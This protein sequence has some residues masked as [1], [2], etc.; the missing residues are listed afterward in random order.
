MA[1]S[2]TTLTVT[3]NENGG[4]EVADA[5]GL[6]YNATITKPTTTRTGYTFNGWYDGNRKWDF[7]NGKVTSDL[8]LTAHWTLNAPG[9][10]LTADKTEA[11]YNG[12]GAVITLTAKPSHA[13]AGVSYTYAWYKDGAVISGATDPT[14]D[15]STVADSGSY[16]VKVT[17]SAWTLTS[18]QAESAAVPVTIGKA[19][20]SYDTPTGLTATYGDTLSQVDLP[21]A[22]S[23]TWAWADSTGDVGGA[24]TQSHEATFTP[25]DKD[26]Y[27]VVENIPVT[28]AVKKKALT[29]SVASVE[30]KVYD[31]SASTTGTIS[32]SGA[33]KGENPAAT[34]T[35]TFADA[36]AGTGKAVNVAVALDSDWGDNYTISAD[37]LE[38]S[39]NITPRPV[40]LTWDYAGP[41]TYTG[42][43]QAVTAAVANA[44]GED[45]FE[46]AY[47]DNEKTD[48]GTYTARVTGLGNG[49][50]T[51]DGGTGATQEWVI[52]PAEI[53]FTVSGNS[54]VYD[55]QPKIAEASQTPGEEPRIDPG[56]YTVTYDGAESQTN[57]GEY[58]ITVTL[59]DSNFTFAGNQNSAVVG[60]LT[61]G[62]AQV[63]I[64]AGDGTKFFYD[65]Q[66]KT[67]KIPDNDGYDVTGQTQTNAGHYTVTVSLKDNYV[68]TDG[69][70][71]EKEYDFVIDPKPITG[72]WDGLRQ[73]YGDNTPVTVTLLGLAEGDSAADV[74][75]A[76]ID[77]TGF[78][79]GDHTITAALTGDKAGNYTLTN[80]TK[81]LTVNQKPLIFT[82]SGNTVQ[83][84]NVTAP[85]VTPSA[86]NFN[87]F[88]IVYKQGGTALTGLPSAPGV[89]EV[90]VELTDNNYTLSGGQSVGKVGDF[91]ITTTPP[92]LYT[93]SFASGGSGHG[94]EPQRVAA[95]STLTLPENPLTYAGHRF[96][97][98]QAEGENRIY[99]PGSVYIMPGRDVTFNAQWT[100]TFSVNGNVTVPGDG[101]AATLASDVKVSIW[102]GAERLAEDTTGKNGSFSFSDLLPGVYNLVATRGEQT[103]TVMVEITDKD[104]DLAIRMPA[105]GTANSVVEVAPAAPPVVADGV[106][107]VAAMEKPEINTT[108]TITLSVEPEQDADEQ[109]AVNEAIPAASQEDALYLDI[110]LTKTKTTNGQTSSDGGDIGSTNQ[111][112]LELLVPYDF[113]GKDTVTVY[114]KHGTEDAMALTALSAKPGTA[115][116]D[117]TFYADK[118]NGRVYIYASKFSTY[119]IAYTVQGSTG[120]GGGSGGGGG[121]SSRPTYAPE[122]E[123]GAHGDVTVSPKR[124][125]RGD[126]VIITPKPDEGYEAVDVSVVDQDGKPVGVEQNE[127]GTWSFIQPSG[128]VTIEVIFREIGQTG[129]C[130]RDNTCP[131][132]KF[133]DVD[134]NAWYHDG[135]HYCLE[136]GLMAGTGASTFSPASTTTR[137][138]IVTIL[139]RQA[140]SPVVNY[141]MDFS[142][143]PADAYYTEA[144]RWAASEGVAGGYGNGK[145]GSNDPITREQLAAMLYHYAQKYGY[146]VS[147]GEDTN[148]LSYTDFGQI[149]EYAVPAMQWACG[150]GI[151][152]G[153]SASTLSPQGWT[154]RAQAAT[155]LERF[156]EQ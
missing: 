4:S 43:P 154:T 54:H 132:A 56:K 74:Y 86:A 87:G 7:E 3:F 44:V 107:D 18:A 115:F 93:A 13:A 24:G 55:G 1:A 88:T 103:V 20:P 99:Q 96:T 76:D 112:V 142:D 51:L 70:T 8:T 38:T 11:T 101:E 53:T 75:V 152:N 137:G 114:R 147:V 155:M 153:T 117:G 72:T 126:K 81:T 106:Q 49:N 58:D 29:P 82:V 79:V 128:K 69:T 32:L 104:Q 91:T 85:T 31:G 121:G 124:P 125:E 62:R 61:I 45:V 116:Q 23:G 68:W 80:A 39:A 14:L 134:M 127:D 109:T 156:C 16:T 52:R 50:Y 10:T 60:T 65:G 146:D 42:G 135:V 22:G 102:L 12:G 129:D 37:K 19:A 131:M 63:D 5:S 123:T 66:E 36:N 48:Q 78:N 141:L 41:L 111:T 150:A 84:G 27:K 57:H 21:N 30:G 28:V 95:G 144:V 46:L 98:W 83:E 140:G 110:A 100:E 97:G 120:G 119:A 6:S 149:S 151:I 33:V 139:W 108:V 133:T 89:Y 64:P 59:T 143:V 118:E 73:T 26:N 71:T 25:T 35:F 94:P 113:T 17:A 15:L 148:I 92:V 130:P 145:F 40:T 105:D 122:I 47:K 90:W 136:S 138:Q 2:G 9:V 67:Y 77:T 34:G